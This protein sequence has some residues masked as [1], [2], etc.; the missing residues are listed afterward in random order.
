MY[1][2]PVFN[3]E[4]VMGGV[5]DLDFKETLYENID[6]DARSDEEIIASGNYQCK[7]DLYK[8][9]QELE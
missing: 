2:F 4:C 3:D 6:F 5:N 9:F 7:Q 8:S 1:Q